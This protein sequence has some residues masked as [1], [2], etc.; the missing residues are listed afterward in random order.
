MKRLLF[1]TCAIVFADTIFYAVLVPLVPYFAEEF[2][3]SKS[4]VGVL[5]GAFGVGILAGSAP[6]AY[7][8]SRV[9]VKAT[10][11]L[12]L[13]L[14]AAT[15]LPFGFVGE[16]WALVLLRFG[17]GFGSALSW[18]SAFTWVVMRAPEEKRGQMIGT[19]ISAAVVAT[20]VGPPLGSLADAIG[21]VPVFVGVAILG[22]LVAFWALLTPA[23]PAA[24]VTPEFRALGAVFRPALFS[25]LWLI[26]LSPLLFGAL[27]VLS[28]LEFD[29]LGWGAAAIAGV[30]LVGAAVEAAVHPLAGRWSDKSGYRPPILTGLL[31]S[32]ALLLALPWAG[33]ALL[34]ALLVI[35]AAALF[36]FALTPGTALLTNGAE[37]VGIGAALAFGLTNF[38]WAS[39]YAAGASLGGLLADVGGDALSYLSLAGVCAATLLLMRWGLQRA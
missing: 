2:G 20:L 33:S 13:G 4:A 11:V 15:S 8:A 29:R 25:G 5:S 23:P 3:L 1:L 6:G 37:K 24:G 27:A 28:P 26:L 34:L 36:N 39:G 38:A 22:L 35:L 17:E 9:G 31:C 10:A 12:G 14:L 7:L 32:V 19:L 16:A 18:V 21:L 30:F